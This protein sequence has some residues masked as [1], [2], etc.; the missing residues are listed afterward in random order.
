MVESAPFND[1]AANMGLSTLEVSQR[2]AAGLGNTSQVGPTRTLSEIIRANVFTPINAIIAVGL[3]LILIA[4]PGPDALFAGVILSNSAIGIIQELRA[5]HT[6]AKLRLLNAPTVRARRDGEVTTITTEDVVQDDIVVLGPGDQV[7]VDGTVV[8]SASLEIDESLLTGESDPIMKGLGDRVLSGSFVAAGSGAF[9]ATDVGEQSYAA[10][11]AAEARQFTQIDSELR[12]GVNRVLRVLVFIIPPVSLVLFWRLLNSEPGWR[13]ALRGTVAAAVAMVPDGLVLLTSLAF[14]AGVIA[15]ARQKVLSRELASVELLARVSVLCLDKTGTLTTGRVVLSHLELFDG[16]DEK[17]VEAALGALGAV[18]SNPNATLRAIAAQFPAPSG[19]HADEVVPFSSARKW[20][21]ASFG[22]NGA[23]AIGAPDVLAP[24]D[25]DV[26]AKLAP[27]A[28]LGQRVVLIAQTP[29]LTTTSIGHHVTPLALVVL[30]DEIRPDA[31]RIMSFLRD[32]GVQ[33]KVISGDHPQ[34]VDAIARRIGM[35][36][37]TD[38]AAPVDG[39]ELPEDPAELA[40]VMQS[41]TVFGRVSP[42]QKRSMVLALQSKGHIVAMTGDGVNDVLALKAADMGIAMG[43]GSDAARAV[44]EIVL[45]DNDFATFPRVLAESRRVINNVERSA[46]LFIVGTVYSILVSV[47]ISL[48]GAEFP[49]LP[50][51]LTLV[52]SLTIGVPGVFLALAANTKRSRPG[53]IA[54]VV[55]F[56]IPVG[57]VMAAASLGTYFTCS[58]ALNLSLVESRTAASLS[59]LGAGLAVLAVLARP[60]NK[61][62]V[63]LVAA[64]P[65]GAAIVLVSAP[66]RDFFAL[67]TPS[68]EAWLVIAVSAI[69]ASLALI[70]H[71]W[72]ADRRPPDAT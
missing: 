70:L 61:A 62:R 20:A 71:Q 2:V 25:A 64:M 59:L 6:L 27:L 11:L 35:Y 63:A 21:G 8:E 29:N 47:I 48:T 22:A 52:R 14:L 13:E 5:R 37:G 15:L 50:R 33:L 44:A 26:A 39:R 65:C 9:V 46:H 12:S 23:F 41:S 1:R 69:S 54:R 60:L 16:A 19:W 51:H 31:S 38:T 24:H 53:F 67:V 4:S 49:F 43:A 40:N 66:L 55:R 7:V 68:A 36:E 34:T 57:A 28:A 18:D 56:S 10:R 3:V 58:D 45:L 30:D 32:E 72:L 42:Q 17:L